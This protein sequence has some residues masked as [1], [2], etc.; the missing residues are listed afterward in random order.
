M[1]CPI[2]IFSPHKQYNYVFPHKSKRT[3][4]FPTRG[5][6]ELMSTSEKREQLYEAGTTSYGIMEIMQMRS[7]LLK[8]LTQ[9]EVMQITK[10]L[11]TR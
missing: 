9:G 4:H 11:D 10:V 2:W 6:Q 3:D 8:T 5:E 1:F 7:G